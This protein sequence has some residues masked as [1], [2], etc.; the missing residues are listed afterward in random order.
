VKPEHT[1]EFEAAM[2]GN[3]ISNIGMVDDKKTLQFTHDGNS[4][5]KVKLSK[6]LDSWKDTLNMG[7]GH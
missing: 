7:G 6:L 4:I 1:A 3:A 2:A 5:L